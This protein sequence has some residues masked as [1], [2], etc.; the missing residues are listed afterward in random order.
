MLRV[1]PIQDIKHALLI[2]NIREL[3][4]A[5]GYCHARCVHSWRS[6]TVEDRYAADALH[7]C[8]DFGLRM[9]STEMFRKGGKRQSVEYL[10]SSSGSPVSWAKTWDAGII[11]REKD[12]AQI[13]VLHRSDWKGSAI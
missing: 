3:I 5:H 10:Y 13:E 12:L 2:S 11:D 4:T 9:I 7:Y 6:A 1:R 8:V